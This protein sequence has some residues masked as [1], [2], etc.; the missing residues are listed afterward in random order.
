[1]PTGVWRR[2]WGLETA[3][4]RPR[5]RPGRPP[6]SHAGC[7]GSRSRSL[8]ARGRVGCVLSTGGCAHARARAGRW[9]CS[10]VPCRLSRHVCRVAG[11]AGDSCSVA[12][13]PA[14][15]VAVRICLS[16]ASPLRARHRRAAW[17]AGR[18]GS[19]PVI[20]GVGRGG[21]GYSVHTY[22]SHVPHTIYYVTTHKLISRRPDPKG[23]L[24][25]CLNGMNS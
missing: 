23:V 4:N 5:R 19:A 11:A 24:Y 25:A 14:V 8:S 20:N 16:L 1:M 18:R 13:R 2:L 15:S 7:S 17:R 22:I 10:A 3:P 6:S 21:A 9:S 12:A